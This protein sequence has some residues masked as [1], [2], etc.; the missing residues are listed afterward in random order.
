MKRVVLFVIA[1]VAVGVVIVM[2][3]AQKKAPD[4]SGPVAKFTPVPQPAAAS[5]PVYTPAPR[6]EPSASPKPS[7]AAPAWESKIDQVLRANLDETQ[8]AQLLLGLLPTLPEDGQVEAAN[9]ITNLLADENYAQAKPVLLNPGLPESVL[10]VFFSD[11]MNR[12]D[13]VKLR[14]LLDVAKIPNHP[15]HDEALS[16]LQIYLGEDYESDW[17]KWS[18]ALERYLKTS[19]TP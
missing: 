9:H 14:A 17:S 7:E 2:A 12:S 5:A 1:T 13:P 4:T 3:L 11:L 10:S 6:A 19:E 8:A 16:D 18:A 15:F